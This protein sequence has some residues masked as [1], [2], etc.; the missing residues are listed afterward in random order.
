MRLRLT[1]LAVLALA[2]CGA[3]SPLAPSATSSD[4]A[5]DAGVVPQGAAEAGCTPGIR[6][7]PLA[8]FGP[9]QN[10]YSGPAAVFSSNFETDGCNLYWLALSDEGE[11]AQIVW[12]GLPR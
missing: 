5:S 9:L 2:G 8:G 6:R 4:E 3:R 10:L 12:R 1:L 7:V 11:P